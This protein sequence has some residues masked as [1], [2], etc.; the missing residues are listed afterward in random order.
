MDTREIIE[1]CIKK[2]ENAFRLL[3]DRFSGYA[4]SVAY[5]IVNDEEESKDIIQESFISV[6][7]KIED[8]DK[9]LNFQNWLY[10]IIVNKCY[11]SM[12]R[13]KRMVLIHPKI[14]NW[15]ILG[16]ASDNNP[17]VKMNNKQIGDMIRLFTKRLSNRQK[18]VFILSELE[19][20]PHDDISE[21]T[22]MA[23]TSVKS[24]LNHARRKI[25]RMVE[26][27]I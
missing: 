2:D 20:L 14:N 6:W 23:K 22:G 13:K 25:G 11:D 16:L 5:R 17:E 12:R 10:K 26:K 8:F 7:N 19:G 15:D 24:N 1:N 21:I 18:I 27:Y 3:L 4:F 9:E